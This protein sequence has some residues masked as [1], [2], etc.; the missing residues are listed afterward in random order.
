MAIFTQSLVCRQ[1]GLNHTAADGSEKVIL[2]EID[3]EAKS[4]EFSLVTGAVGAGKSSLLHILA[5]LQRPT[6]GVL[7]ADGQPVSRWTGA[8][9]DRWRRQVG[10]VFQHPHLLRD[11]TVLENVMLPMVPGARSLSAIRRRALQRLEELQIA[12]LAGETVR[13][14]SGGELQRVSLARALAPAPG[15][16]IAD[17]P[18]AHQDEKGADLVTALLEQLKKKRAIVIVACHDERRQRWSPLVDRKFRL[19][20]G[21]LVQVP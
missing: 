15:I 2:R 17:E 3:L 19:H 8:F 11:L 5:G 9:R 4:G 12:F 6:T 18:T 1:V 14:L 21:R 20:N 10:I 7:V 13:S 16:L